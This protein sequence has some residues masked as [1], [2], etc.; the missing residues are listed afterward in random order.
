M[1]NTL[2][3]Y[4]ISTLLG[5]SGELLASSAPPFL[6]DTANR[7]VAVVITFQPS[8]GPSDAAS[9]AFFLAPSKFE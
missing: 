4:P 9:T 8:H 7:Q 3:R 6:E 1:W 2:R 5:T